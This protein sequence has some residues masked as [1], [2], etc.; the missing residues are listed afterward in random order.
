MSS[1]FVNEFAEMNLINKSEYKIL[2][3]NIRKR[4]DFLLY[5]LSDKKKLLRANVERFYRYL[6]GIDDWES[7]FEIYDNIKKFIEM[8]ES[9]MSESKMNINMCIKQMIKTDMLIFVF[10]STVK[11][12]KDSFELLSFSKLCLVESE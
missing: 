7:N 10:C 8:N 5:S 9:K 3:K 12:C 6:E 1:N 11:S 2:V 4:G